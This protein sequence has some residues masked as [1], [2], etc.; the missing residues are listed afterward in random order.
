M[1][2]AA[3]ALS[4]VLLA[5]GAAPHAA[6]AQDALDRADQ[7]SRVPER[8]RPEAS[9]PK[10]TIPVE[11]DA[12]TAAPEVGAAILVGAVSL[13]GLQ[14][15][16]PA[17]FADIIADRIGRTL[18][19]TELAALATAIAERARGR[20]L[21]F[22]SAWIEPQ[23]LANG[24]LVVRV[25]EGRID[26]VRFD[27]PVPPGVREALA[28][29][30]DGK[31]ARIEQVERRLLLAGDLGGVL[32]RS[33][34]F[35]REGGKGVLLVRVSRERVTGRISL[36]NDGTKAVGPYQAR[37]EADLNALFFADDALSVTYSIT[38]A[39]LNELRYARASYAKRVDGSGTELTL[40]GSSAF[41][42]PGANLTPFGFVSRSWS[43]GASLAQPLVRSRDTSLWLEG[44][45]GLRN[46]AQRRRGTLV[47]HDRVA[48]I[49]MTL[50]GYADVLNGRLRSGLTVSQGL[51]L[52][53]ATGFGDPLASRPRASGSFTS[54]SGWANWTRDLGGGFSLRAAVQSQLAFEPLLVSEEVGLGGTAFL[55]G[56]DWSERSGDQGVMGAAELRYDWRKPL[57]FLRR[58]QLYAFVDG[59]RV[60]NI[61][62][63][64][65]SG[66]L[67]S[68]GGGVRADLTSSFGANFELA[69][70]LTGPRYDT[71]TE[72]PKLNLRLL[73]TF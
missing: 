68:A 23:R 27:G 18:N 37:I 19:S 12:P 30:V 56:Y 45:F 67:A 44:E 59:G 49:R 31:P 36:T 62:D 14:E 55:R 28:P 22:A 13:A 51:Q 53:E 48:T 29:L 2:V 9:A 61:D 42:R 15:L 20:G 40:S 63:D 50:H 58:A 34:R 32:I 65:G 10:P 3:A 41:V 35:L 26:E 57:G 64:Y 39:E 52:L 54:L 71:G 11:V 47:R 17:D 21:A 72:S 8:A 46:L 33:S 4:T 7:A 24:V 69:V 25:D 6:R 60:T 73:K 38:P 1:H 43:L 66:D 5:A 16:A 70:P